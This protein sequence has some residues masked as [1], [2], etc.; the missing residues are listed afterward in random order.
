LRLD[1]VSCSQHRYVCRLGGDEFAV[2]LIGCPIQQAKSIASEIQKQVQEYCFQWND[3][4]YDIGVSL[5][6]TMIDSDSGNTTEVLNK[7]DNACYVAKNTG[8]NLIHVYNDDDVVVQQHR[9]EMQWVQRI[10]QALSDNRFTLFCQAIQPITANHDI[11]YFEILVRMIDEQNNLIGP[12]NFI[13]AAENYQ[14]MTAIDRWVINAA[15]SMLAE[16]NSNNEQQWSF[17]INLSGQSLTDTQVLDYIIETKDKTGI[18]PQCVC[19]E[20]TETAAIRNIS[21]AKKF[22]S[23]LKKSG[24]RFSLDDFGKGMSSFAYLRELDID[25][26]KIDGAFVKQ[27]GENRV[28]YAMVSS[29]NQIGQLMGIQTVAEFVENDH[30]LELIT[31]LQI[32]FAQGYGIDKPKPLLLPGTNKLHKHAG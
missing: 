14:L 25:F 12:Q 30:I 21:F 17:S 13:P 8:R 22:I 9:G 27:I 3:R 15:F 18:N 19:F 32:D 11:Q 23:S 26:L 7:A 6:I 29:I 2:L 24:F 10:T 16:H 20:I 5:G 31:G 4:N 1:K 28:D